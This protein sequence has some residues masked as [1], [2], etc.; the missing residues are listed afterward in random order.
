MSDLPHVNFITLG[1]YSGKSTICR[2]LLYLLGEGEQPT[3][4]DELSERRMFLPPE[5][6][7]RKHR[8]SRGMGYPTYV[9]N[10]RIYNVMD[11][12]WWH[13]ERR[14][15]FLSRAITEASEADTAILVVSARRG[16]FEAG[17]DVHGQSDPDRQF[18]DWPHVQRETQEH[19]RLARIAGIPSIT[20]AIS[21]M[22]TVAPDLQQ[23]RYEHIKAAVTPY[24]EANGY[25]NCVFLPT[26]SRGDDEN[27]L[28]TRYKAT[29]W[30]G[31]S[32][33]DV[34]DNVAP[35]RCDTTQ[36][37]R[38]PIDSCHR[39]HGMMHLDRN[40]SF[41]RTGDELQISGWIASGQVSL[42]DRLLLQPSGITAEVS[43]VGTDQGSVQTACGGYSVTLRLV[44]VLDGDV[45]VHGEVQVGSVATLCGTPFVLTTR[46]LVKVYLTGKKSLIAPGYK[47]TLHVHTLETEAVFEKLYAVASAES[48]K[49]IKRRP[50]FVRGTEV[51]AWRNRC[52]WRRPKTS[53]RWGAFHSGRVM[54]LLALVLSRRCCPW[55][56]RRRS[57]KWRRELRTECQVL[58]IQVARRVVSA[59]WFVFSRACLVLYDSMQC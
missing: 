34:L 30:E 15:L 56:R 35:I 27:G 29:W 31:P 43:D 13:W 9:A 50:L 26:S 20:V 45:R 46:V 25:P 53:A 19:I 6:Q 7:E 17:F 36:K 49:I 51:V 22:D 59:G 38:L 12:H 55:T 33:Q 1:V 37:L 42:G 23:Q 48:G 24:L 2:H 16:E 54:T 32:L 41:Y 58:I 14:T 44:D 21:K 57:R 39:T 8:G 52:V 3:V 28:T 18:E 4:Y 40:H 5:Y 11:P 10:R 47:A